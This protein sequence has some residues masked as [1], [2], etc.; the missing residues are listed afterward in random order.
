MKKLIPLFVLPVIASFLPG[1]DTQNTDPSG[2]PPVADFSF[3]Y[4]HINNK[5]P[6]S[7][8]FTNLSTDANTYTWKF[9]DGNTSNLQDADHI[10]TTPGTFNVWLV[11][12]N[13]SSV[14]SVSHPV[15]I[16]PAPASVRINTFTALSFPSTNMG[17]PWDVPGF[18]DP[19]G[20]P[21][22]YLVLKSQAN[23]ALSQTNPVT[24]ATPP[25]GGE[26]EFTLP[27]FTQTYIIEIYDEDAGTDQLMGSATFNVTS[28]IFTQHDPY[29]SN[30]I[31]NSSSISVYMLFQWNY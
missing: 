23:S 22:V 25:A 16:Y 12:S 8:T 26:L 29:P 19:D 18:S 13:G 21:D 15:I 6:A 4:T 11:A 27:D 5:V 7:V 17:N 3:S 10:Y 24:N 20:D 30:Y 1:C 9:G 2:N 14:D 28:D 31:L